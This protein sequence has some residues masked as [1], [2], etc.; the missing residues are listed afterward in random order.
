MIEPKDS[1]LQVGGLLVLFAAIYMQ[2]INVNSSLSKRVYKFDPWLCPLHMPHMP[3][4][5]SLAVSDI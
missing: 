1:G 4:K 2:P 3:L 5:A